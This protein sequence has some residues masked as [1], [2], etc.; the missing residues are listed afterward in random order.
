MN[1]LVTGAAGFIGSRLSERLLEM[2]HRVRGIDS[3]TDYYPRPLKEGNLIALRDWR[4]FEL[5]EADILEVEPAPTAGGRGGGGAPGGP[6]RG[7][8]RS[9]GANFTIYTQNNMLTTPALAGSGQGDG[10]GPPGLR[11]L[12]QRVRRHQGSA[13][14]RDQRLLA[15]FALWGH[16][17]G[18][19]APLRPVPQELRHGHH[20]PALLHGLVRPPASGRTWPFTALSGALLEGG[21]HPPVRRRRPIQGLHLCGRRGGRHPWP[22]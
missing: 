5:I 6:G 2:G 7:V 3:F 8:R 22:R 16:Q 13:H 21:G 11:Q 10:A 1:I 12:L 9:W 14:A 20:Q 4:A 15:G 17:V 18:R 19:R